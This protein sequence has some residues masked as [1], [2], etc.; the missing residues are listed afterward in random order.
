M[1]FPVYHRYLNVHLHRSGDQDNKTLERLTIY[2]ME[3]GRLLIQSPVETVAL[4]F[5]LTNFGLANM[6]Y[7]LVQ[8]LVKCFEAY[9]P[10]PFSILASV[11]HG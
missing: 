2:L 10:T 5:D 6:D 1:H 9:Y 4:V 11:H 7:S 3:T 8:F